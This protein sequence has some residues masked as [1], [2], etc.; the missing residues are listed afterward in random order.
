[1]EESELTHWIIQ[2]TAIGYAPEF[3]SVKEMVEEIRRQC[4]RQINDNEIECIYYPPLDRKWIKSFI[5]HHSILE[6]IIT[7]DIDII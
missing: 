5:N 4:V 7:I 1:M 2:L 3:G 6:S